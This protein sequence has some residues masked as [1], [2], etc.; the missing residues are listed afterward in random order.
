MVVLDKYLG[1]R[2]GFGYV[3]FYRFYYVVFVFENCDLCK[4]YYCLNQDLWEE[5][6]I[7]KKEKKKNINFFEFLVFYYIK[8]RYMFMYL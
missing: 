2:K 6:R 8:R 7:C 5:L 3:R 1:E 4:F